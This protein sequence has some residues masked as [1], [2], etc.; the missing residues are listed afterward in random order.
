MKKTLRR[1]RLERETLRNLTPEH[2]GQVV[3]GTGGT[4]DDT[5]TRH[6]SCNLAESKP[7]SV[8]QSCLP[9]VC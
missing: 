2:L 3:G 5:D 4:I 8:C 6:N 7:I 9:F 1:L